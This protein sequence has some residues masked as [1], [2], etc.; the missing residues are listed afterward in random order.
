MAMGGGAGMKCQFIFQ[1]ESLMNLAGPTRTKIAP[2]P[3]MQKT[4]A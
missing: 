4:D 2:P 1:V 3:E